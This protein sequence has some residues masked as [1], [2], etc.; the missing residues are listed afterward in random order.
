MIAYIQF[1]QTPLHHA[2][3]K[4]VVELLI[5]SGADVNVKDEVSII[6]RYD[7]TFTATANVLSERQCLYCYNRSCCLS[8]AITMITYIPVSANTIASGA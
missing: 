3:S 2:R 6:Q 5:Q 1:Q 7:I 8:D 4:D